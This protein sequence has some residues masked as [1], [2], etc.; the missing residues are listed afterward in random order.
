[1]HPATFFASAIESGDYLA[2]VAVRAELET[3]IVAGAGML[4]RPMLPRPSREGIVQGLEGSIV[5]V[6]TEP[7]W[8]RLGIAAR[9]MHEVLEYAQTNHIGR[10]LLNAS[11]DGRPLYD[12]LGFV[13]TMEMRL[14]KPMSVEGAT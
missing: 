3:E 1:M 12:K 10:V 6:Y 13:P 8:R 5:N 4:L 11:S 7:A 9:V 14:D 2:W